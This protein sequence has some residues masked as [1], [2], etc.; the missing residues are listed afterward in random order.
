M[1]PR[2]GNILA[3]TGGRDYQASQFNRITPGETTARKLFKPIIAAKALEK[4][5][6][7]DLFSSFKNIPALMERPGLLIITA[8]VLKSKIRA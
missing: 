3:M 6:A 8:R 5:K 4:F 7:S 2:T 1:Q